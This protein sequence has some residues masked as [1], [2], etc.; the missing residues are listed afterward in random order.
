MRMCIPY[1]IS[2][3]KHMAERRSHKFENTFLW[4]HESVYT[5][6]ARA[7]TDS[8]DEMRPVLK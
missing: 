7:T 6:F 8:S 1:A 5:V 3:R 4:P 2:I